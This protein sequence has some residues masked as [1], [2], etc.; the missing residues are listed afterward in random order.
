MDA[1]KSA[2]LPVVPEG[3]RFLRP[4]GRRI[5]PARPAPIGAQIGGP[6][7]MWRPQVREARTVSAASC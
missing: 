7:R 2:R 3:E 1:K 6:D 4:A 5:S